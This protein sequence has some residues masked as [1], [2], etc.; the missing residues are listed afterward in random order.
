[1]VDALV[2]LLCLC[3]AAFF[4]HRFWTDLNQQLV[5]VGEDPI[6]TI[7]FKK[8]AAQRR[9]VERVL[10][11]RLQRDSPVYNGDLIRTAEISEA[12]VTFVNG[13][14]MINLEENSLIQIFADENGPR[15]DFSTGTISVESGQSGIELVSGGKTVTV[16]EGGTVK[17]N[18]GGTDG[19]HLMVASGRAQIVDADGTA[20]WVEEKSGVFYNSDG[21]IDT[22]PRSLVYAPKPD[23]KMTHSLNE[24]LPMEFLWTNSNYADGM[25][26]RVE[27]SS[28][29]NFHTIL[30]RADFTALERAEMDI[31]IGNIYWRAYPVVSDDATRNY[32]ANAYTGKISLSYAPEPRL[33]APASNETITYRNLLPSIRYQWTGSS[34]PLYFRLVVAD[35]EALADPVTTMNVRGT[36]QVVQAPG[37]GVWYWRVEPVYAPDV[38]GTPKASPV[39]SFRV[40]Q[41]PGSLPSPSLMLP[42]LGGVISID[43]NG[44]DSYFAWEGDAE[45]VSSTI[46]IS[47]DKNLSSP[48]IEATVTENYYT[49]STKK[50]G[51][52]QSGE[53]YWAVRQTDTSG[54]VSPTSEPRLFYA[55][56]FAEDVKPLPSPV[57]TYPAEG[58]RIMLSDAPVTFRWRPVAGADNYSFQ[59]YRV[60]GERELAHTQ[61][62][63]TTLSLSLPLTSGQYVCT[64]RAVGASKAEGMER[65][66]A[67]EE[68]MF[69]ARTVSPVTPVFPER[70]AVIEGITTIRPGISARW[71]TSE[72]LR[73]SRFIL[74]RNPDPLQGTPVMDVWNPSVPLPLPR[75]AEGTYYWTVLAETVDGYSVSARAPTQFRVTPLAPVPATLDSPGS[76]AELTQAEAR[77]AG[78]IQ[79]SSAEPPARSR[80]VLSRNPDPLAGTP[81][82]NVQNPSR[83]INLPALEPGVYY[84]TITGTS[85]DGIDISARAPSMFR[86]L[87]PEPLAAA[88]CL[89]PENGGSLEPEK[90]RAERRIIFTWEAVEGANEYEFV[91]LKDGEKREPLLTGKTVNGLIF[92]VDDLVPFAQGGDFVWQVTAR[93]RGTD[94]RVERAGI[95][96]ESRFSVNIP[97][98]ARGQAYSPGLLYGR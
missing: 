74:S 61:D 53:Y 8:K 70:G 89:F 39:S 64:L 15:V 5:K 26:T 24:P 81:V 6:G 4:A 75:L 79:W 21:T 29:R 31:P 62:A 68:I 14:Q 88:R 97:H 32:L 72:P 55:S 30:K 66:S 69:T 71:T 27:L 41:T 96:G 3:A 10:W 43:P 85:T 33:A 84:W 2:V 48:V 54:L 28:D 9:F 47:R 86:I 38:G 52:L 13:G 7:T 90:L 51:M 12:T 63:I 45:A 46:I 49:Y 57:I 44:P 80:F 42:V 67:V 94:G 77:R 73:T 59:L 25:V 92:T 58:A 76:G 83:S 37:E 65:V 82:L 98:P 17:L 95:A 60:D 16:T 11:G 18:T 78:V 87:P 91:L 50:S 40:V 36:A 35:N 93:Y 56:L 20:S 1:M 19:L 23:L 34:E 22:G